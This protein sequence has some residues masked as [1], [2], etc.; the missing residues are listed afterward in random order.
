MHRVEAAPFTFRK[1]QVA[2]IISNIAKMY[3]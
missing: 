1:A 2:S 3:K